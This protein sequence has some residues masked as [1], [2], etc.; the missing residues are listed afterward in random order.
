[1]DKTSFDI[2]I[3]GLGVMGRNFALNIADHG[4][5][6]A[7]YDGNSSKSALLTSLGGNEKHVY[8]ALTLQEFVTILTRPKKILLFVP[9][10]LPVDEVIKGLMPFLENGDII[11]DGGNSY[12]H[13]TESRQRMLMQK[14]VF[15]LGAGIS[16]GEHGAR[17]GASIMVGGDRDAY[18]NVKEIL[19][20][21]AAVTNDGLTIEYMGPGGSGHY[22]KMV[23]NGIEY[24]IMQL[25]AEAYDLAHR[26]LGLSSDELAQLFMQWNASSLNSYLIEI[27]SEIFKRTDPFSEG[28]LIDHIRDEAKQKG[29]GRWAT[30]EAMKLGAVTTIIDTAVQMRFLSSE[31]EMRDVSSRLFGEEILKI[32]IN[33]SAMFNHLQNALYSSIIMTYA[34]GFNLLH[35]ASGTYHYNIPLEMVVRIWNAGSIIRSEILD[36]FRSVYLENPEISNPILNKRLANEI[37][38]R[39]ENICAVMI[40]ACSC[41]FSVPAFGAA[42]SY[43]DALRSRRLPANLI[44][45]QRDYF[46]AHMY[47]RIDRDGSFH[48]DWEKFQEDR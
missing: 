20:T 7:G 16:G 26:G 6:V 14:G 28:Y 38:V 31:K 22:V 4:F 37:S 24:G 36:H 46:G 19:Q 30:E 9:A 41:G 21:C 25:I 3:I 40:E 11:I 27:T 2:G 34:Q 44:Q 29:T 47:E 8:G 12:F 43:Y 39:R 32:G 10:G 35:I 5:R 15:F 48:T 45:A 23:H 42:I 13:D 1:M 18:E 17:S 33:R